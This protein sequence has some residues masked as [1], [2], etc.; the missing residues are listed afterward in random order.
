[1]V[2]TEPETLTPAEVEARIRAVF[3]IWKTLD[4]ASIADL[5]SG[6][7][8]FGYRSREARPPYETKEAYCEALRSWLGM[9]EHYTIDIEQVETAVDG[10][11]GLAWGF[12]KEEFALRGREPEVISGRFSEVM[13]RDPSGWRTL[14]YQRDAQPFDSTGRYIPSATHSG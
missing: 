12:Y 4:P 1:V 3:G 5:Y 11:V 9:F 2:S 6:G 13:R 14:L 10:D 7:V 8:G